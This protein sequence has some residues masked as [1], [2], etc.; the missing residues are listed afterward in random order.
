MS[1]IKALLGTTTTVMAYRSGNVALARTAAR[2]LRLDV[3]GREG[4]SR[5]NTIDNAADRLAVALA[6]GVDAV[7]RSEGRHGGL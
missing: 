1:N 7:E 2:E 4:E 5:G 6:V 3:L